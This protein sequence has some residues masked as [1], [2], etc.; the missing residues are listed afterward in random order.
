MFIGTR[1]KKLRKEKGLTQTEL[2]SMLNV[3]KVSI[4][5]YEKNVRVPSLETLEDIS[6]IFG[7]SCDYFLGKDIPGVRED[8]PDYAFYISKE[9]MDFLKLLRLN[10]D[11]YSKL[12]SDPKRLIELIDKKLK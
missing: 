12:N 4:C 6:N 8:T 5:C 9:E 10:K 3:T 11:L 1:L 2:G 7:L